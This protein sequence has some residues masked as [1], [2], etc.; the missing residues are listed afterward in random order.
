MEKKGLC[1]QYILFYE[2]FEGSSANS[3]G[4]VSYSGSTKCLGLYAMNLD[5]FL[6]KTMFYLLKFTENKSTSDSL[7]DDLAFSF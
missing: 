1:L 6:P 5:T 4:L 7:H 3:T 2:G